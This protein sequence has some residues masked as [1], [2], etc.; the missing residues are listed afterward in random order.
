[1]LLFVILLCIPVTVPKLFGHQIYNVISGS[2][3][4]EIP[5]GSLIYTSTATPESI[6]AGDI[7]AF[8]NYESSTPITHRV[9]ENQA[10]L[11]QFI[12]KG[13]ANEDK[14]REP[15]PY[16]N[17]IGKVTRHIP[18]LG[19]YFSLFTSVGGKMMVGCII[20][21]SIF[22]HMLANAMEKKKK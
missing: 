18:Y 19:N 6:Q 15:I 2:M 11:N 21:L 13:D 17:Y 3:E 10:D 20:A 4:P 22:L 5:I 7:I 1:M 16:S 12:T 14:D 8:Y 9:V